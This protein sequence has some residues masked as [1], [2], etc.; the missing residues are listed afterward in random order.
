VETQKPQTLLPLPQEFR[1]A[2]VITRILN[3][4]HLI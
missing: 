2:P 1:Q 3:E 4:D